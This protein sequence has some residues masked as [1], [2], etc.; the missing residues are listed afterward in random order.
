MAT[1]ARNFP[2]ERSQAEWLREQA[3][4]TKRSQAEMVREAL[5][6]YQAK[7]DGEDKAAIHRALTEQFTHGIGID[8]E[9]LRN[10]ESVMYDREP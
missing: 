9:L 7:V 4:R 10:H 1:I 2:I 8:L 3:L 5:S 6:D